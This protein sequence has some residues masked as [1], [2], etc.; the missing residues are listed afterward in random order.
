MT[1]LPNE[2]KEPQSKSNYTLPYKQ[3]G[4]FKFRVLDN[5]VVGFE[6]WKT[7]GE[8]KIPIRHKTGEEPPFGEDGKEPKYFWA[9]PVFNY[10]QD[11]IQIMVVTQ[12]TIRNQMQALIDNEVWGNPQSYDI[13]FTRKGLELADTTYT[14]MPNPHTELKPEILETY[15]RANLSLEDWFKGLDP[16]AKKDSLESQN[17]PLANDSGEEQV[18]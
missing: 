13:T 5:A 15:K 4:S 3:E 12:K 1:F 17:N 9:F 18:M 11:R 14:I 10:T 8:K 7:E 2:A 16:F 6:T